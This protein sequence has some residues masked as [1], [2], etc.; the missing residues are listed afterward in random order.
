VLEKSNSFDPV[1]TSGTKFSNVENPTASSDDVISFS[2]LG[3]S[4]DVIARLHEKLSITN[5]T[6]TQIS[7]LSYILSGRD[8]IL[9]AET[10][11]GKTLAYLLPMI[12]LFVKRLREYDAHVKNSSS[13]NADEFV[14]PLLPV[15]LIVVPTQELVLQIFNIMSKLY[16]E[17]VPY[18]KCVYKNYGVKRSESSGIII[19]TPYALQENVNYKVLADLKLVV[20]DECDTLLS[21]HFFK[22]VQGYL[23]STLKQRHITIRPQTCFV[24]ATLPSKGTKSIEAFLNTYYPEPSTMRI[25]TKDT[26]K[27]LEKLHQTFIQLDSR[28]PLLRREIEAQEKIEAKIEKAKHEAKKLLLENELNQVDESSSDDINDSNQE[29]SDKIATLMSDRAMEDYIQTLKAE[30]SLYL[31]TVLK[32]RVQG[33]VLMLRESLFWNSNVDR[34]K[35]Q[36]KEPSSMNRKE[37]KRLSRSATSITAL[38]NHVDLVD[39]RDKEIDTQR[40]MLSKTQLHSHLSSLAQ[41]PDGLYSFQPLPTVAMSNLEFER[42]M[43]TIIFVNSGET[44]EAIRKTILTQNPSIEPYSIA[45]L[46]K[47]IDDDVRLQRLKLFAEGAIKVLVCTDVASR[48]LDTVNVGHV[49]QAEFSNDA[50]T[51]LHR[52]G[53][54][55]RAGKE[56]RATN[57]FV[58]K[59]ATLVQTLL[60]SYSNKSAISDAFS[61]KRSFQR[62]L[63]RAKIADAEEHV[64]SEMSNP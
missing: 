37:L 16:P 56:G 28:L 22:S 13:E 29:K 64:L 12:E 34:T 24:G 33:I 20:L 55:A 63:I 60:D 61:R 11:S 42:L 18:F 54:T 52:V 39:Q 4:E 53:R 15:G 17:Y 46:H 48:G 6:P 8:V 57:F 23:L 36:V 26:H 62:S 41:R 32:Y 51:H 27:H 40:T 7:S 38:S 58:R 21:G 47:R 45:T 5:P 50:V 1:S 14:L 2:D 59:N 25:F 10:G 43:P 3:L 31:D 19:S 30:E 44:A 49:I 35:D 9:V